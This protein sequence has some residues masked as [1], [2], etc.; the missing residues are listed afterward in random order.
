MTETFQL[1][2]LKTFKEEAPILLIKGIAFLIENKDI[3]KTIEKYK[4]FKIPDYLKRI[5]HLDNNKSL[6]L[7]CTDHF[8]STEPGEY[9]P[10]DDFF[11]KFDFDRSF[12][13][14]TVYVPNRRF[15]NVKEW[16]AHKSIWPCIFFNKKEEDLN[17]NEIKNNFKILE[18]FENPI[19]S[20]M[21]LIVDKQIIK[22]EYDTNDILGHAILN[23]ISDV[24]QQEIN[25]L[26]TGLDAYLSHEPCISCAM[27]LVHGRIKRVFIKNKRK[28]G[29]FTKYKLCYNENLNHRYPVY[30][31]DQCRANGAP[32]RTRAP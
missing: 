27:A 6:F 3:S 24:S 20:G 14:Y 28:N 17:L 4:N 30:F 29:P 16:E 23:A 15:L 22:K 7:C 25:Y 9:Y 26:C 32:R 11:T 5:K 19:C 31:L 12:K 2:R 21:C 1:K 13:Y 18:N 10:D 8:I